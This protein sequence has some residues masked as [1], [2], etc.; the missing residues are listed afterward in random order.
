MTAKA[1]ILVVDDEPFFREEVVAFYEAN[2]ER[3]GGRPL[4]DV[5]G[6]IVRMLKQ[7]AITLTAQEGAQVYVDGKLVG[8]TPLRRP[9]D[10]EVGRHSVSVRKPGF[11]TWTTEITVEARKTLPLRITLSPSY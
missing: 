6:Q 2:K 7:G 4:E 1:R 10:V 9:I 5:D 11:N 8:I 3:A